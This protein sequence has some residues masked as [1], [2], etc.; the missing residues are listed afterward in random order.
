[1]IQ[2]IQIAD[3]EWVKKIIVVDAGSSRSTNLRRDAYVMIIA[4]IS[5]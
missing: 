2:L 1:M 3:M 4:W 5:S